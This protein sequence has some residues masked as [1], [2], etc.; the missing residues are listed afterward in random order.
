MNN[1][2]TVISD[3]Q[4]QDV[5]PKSD[6]DE[7]LRK[8]EVYSDTSSIA[9][10][11]LIALL[12]GFG[13][14]LVWAAFAPLDEGVPTPGV[15]SIEAKRNVVQHLTGGIVK[16]VLVKEGQFVNAGQ[17][18]LK[19]DEA[20]TKANF[21]SIR[22][23]FLGLSAMQTR[24]LAEQAGASQL[25]FREEVVQAASTDPYIAQQVSNQKQLFH[26]RRQGFNAD[27]QAIQEAMHGA[28][29]QKSANLEMLEQR[30]TQMTLLNEELE[31]IKG[32]VKDGY[33]PRNRQLELQ[34]QQAELRAV[35]SDLMGSS[36]R[37]TR[38]IMELEQ[39]LISKR[40]EYR[41]E[42]EVQLAD[43]SREVQADAEKFVAASNDLRRV[44]ITAPVEGQVIGL[45]V[46]NVGSVIQPGQK[47]M[48]VVPKDQKLLLETKIA[49]HLIDKVRPGLE[50]DV[51]FSAFAHSPQLVVQAKILS[52]SGDL[53]TESNNPQISYYLARLQVTDEGV[54]TLGNRQMQAGMPVEV[55][56]KTG[57]RTMLTYLLGPLTRRIASSMKEE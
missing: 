4:I 53:L 43:V 40:S 13:G 11:G 7:N 54:E 33:A 39:R 51:R 37:L 14:F 45:T 10:K 29:A 12:I 44:D 6:T 2:F 49:P 17:V 1:K 3:S 15:V 21:E 20:V 52:V 23:R 50:A 31:N 25:K 28:I 41:K 55:V 22:Q 47:L 57:S 19:L 34:R 27:M 5:S 26:S 24:L 42:V 36:E 9:K 30:K 18:L 16:E 48:D 8:L 46:H 56:I 32:L 35:V 38:T